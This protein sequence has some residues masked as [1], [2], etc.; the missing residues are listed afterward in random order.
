PDGDFLV[1][2][3]SPLLTPKTNQIPMELL[4]QIK[5]RRDLLYYHWEMTQERVFESKYVSQANDLAHLRKGLS[6]LLVGW[7]DEM[8]KRL[9]NTATEI[10]LLSPTELKL[11]R[12]SHVGLTG[13]ELVTLARWLNSPSFPHYEPPP[14]ILRK[15]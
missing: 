13:A 4:D 9:G 10:A 1:V 8:A 7:L 11:V 15:P 14:P 5:S 3:L 12:K 6:Q 2:G